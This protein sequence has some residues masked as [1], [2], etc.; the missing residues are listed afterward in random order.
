MRGSAGAAENLGESLLQQSITVETWV[1]RKAQSA[2]LIGLRDKNWSDQDIK[3][4]L[5]V[6]GL[7][8]KL[9]P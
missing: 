9:C 2:V 4:I 3:H 1:L 6:L 8:R 7:D 5:E